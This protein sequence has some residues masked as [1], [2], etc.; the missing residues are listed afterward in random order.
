LR[1]GSSVD[2]WKQLIN[3]WSD[4]ARDKVPAVGQA[5]RDDRLNVEHV[6]GAVTGRNIE[7]V[8]VLDGNADQAG[9]G[10]LRR[11]PECI[12][13]LRCVRRFVGSIG[14]LVLSQ[15]GCYQEQEGQESSKY[16]GPV[17]EYAHRATLHPSE[18]FSRCMVGRGFSRRT[19]LRVTGGHCMRS[20]ADGRLVPSSI[21]AGQERDS[22]VGAIALLGLVV[23]VFVLV[24]FAAAF[25]V[26]LHRHWT[27]IAVR[28]VGSWIAAS[29]LLML[30]WALR[31]G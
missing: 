16:L 2:G 12:G 20:T 31:R 18:L 6:L 19:L 27:R 29:G 25:A 15:K 5:Y 7:V 17:Y 22:E 3:D 8:V 13:I 14:R 9:Y 28:V 10:V 21:E 23:A 24:V 11:L 30:G 1:S 26:P 4:D